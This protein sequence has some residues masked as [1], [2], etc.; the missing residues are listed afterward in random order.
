M[1]PSLKVEV[2][3]LLR[4]LLGKF[5]V[6]GAIA[7]T[8][9]GLNEINLSDPALQLVDNELGIGHEAWSYLSEEE[10]YFDPST[11]NIFFNGV[12]D[13]YTAVTSTILKKFSFNDHVFDDVTILLPENLCN[14]SSTA[15]MRLARRFSTA[16]PSE[17]LD[18]QQEEVLDYKLSPQSDFPDV[19]Q[20]GKERHEDHELCPYWQS[21]GEMKTLCGTTRF[22]NLSKLSKCLLALP[23]SN[24]ETERVF[25]IVR[26]IVTDYRSQMDQST[27]CAFISCKVNNDGVC[28][29]DTHTILLKEA[30][31]AP[32]K[33]NSAHSSK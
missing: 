22:P 20:E 4:I 10:D 13:F 5:L 28:F 11:L 23:V 21:V 14:L 1:L 6:S 32:I 7:T 12:R 33:Y 24:A 3:R 15:V 26:K 16:V 2:L 27:L 18:V 9:E 17:L 8:H 25:S 30:K 31:S 19:D 29:L